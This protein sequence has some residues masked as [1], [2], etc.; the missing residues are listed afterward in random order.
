MSRYRGK[1]VKLNKLVIGFLLMFLLSISVASASHDS[2]GYYGSNTDRYYEDYQ[3]D[4]TFDSTE[5]FVRNSN[6]DYNDPYYYGYSPYNRYGGSV[7]DF[8]SYS[9]QTSFER[10]DRYTRSFETDRYSR[11]NRYYNN[12]NSYGNFG[13]PYSGGYGNNFRDSRNSYYGNDYGNNYGANSFRNSY[14]NGYGNNNGYYDSFGR[15]VPSYSY[16]SRY[17]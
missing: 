9:S 17:Y 4:Y 5:S 7:S 16:N 2:F 15:G 8:E 10:H 11:P 1:I 14:G 3:R 13:N 6:V 12:Y